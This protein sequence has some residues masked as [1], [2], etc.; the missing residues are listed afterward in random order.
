MV[1]TA[2]SGFEVFMERIAKMTPGDSIPEMAARFG[3]S[4]VGPPIAQRFWPIN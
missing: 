4:F 3:I 1:L 2:P